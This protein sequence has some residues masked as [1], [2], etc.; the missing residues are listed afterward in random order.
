MCGADTVRFHPLT[1]LDEGEE[2]VVGRTDIDS[3]AVLPPDGADLLRRLTGGEA[4]ELAAAWYRRTHG[5]DVDVT[6]FL[7]AMREFGFVDDGPPDAAGSRPPTPVR[8]QR[9]GRAAFSPLAWVLYAGL[10]AAAVMACVADP[11]LAPR[12]SHVFFTDSLIVIELTI[13]VLQTPLTLVHE[14]FHVLAGRRLGLNTRI[15]LSHRFVVVVFETVMDGL[16]AVPRRKRYLPM[17]AGLLADLLVVSAA[18]LLAW[19]LRGPGQHLPGAPTAAA[20]SLAVAFTTLPRMAWQGYVFLRTDLYH[21]VV[22]VLGCQDLHGAARARLHN[23]VAARLPRRVPARAAWRT[24]VDETAWGR[25]DRAAAG[26]YAWLMVA[27][28]GLAGAVTVLVMIPLAWRFFATAVDRAL[29]GGA[30]GT[31]QLLDSALILA[32]N[33]GQLLLAGWLAVRERRRRRAPRTR[34]GTRPGSGPRPGSTDAPSEGHRPD[35]EPLAV[36][37]GTPA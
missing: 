14:W 30:G 1:F 28:Y 20:V 21:L 11:G 7:E 33:G 16:V 24:P 9:L 36:L 8:W 15:R 34:A 6:G 17:L 10:V 5:E 22:T 32:L 12:H 18:T 23:A 37:E 31:G 26:W 4:P 35:P 19:A 29:L 2:V 13:L 25:R 27:G 3:Y